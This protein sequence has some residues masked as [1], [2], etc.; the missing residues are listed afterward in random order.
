MAPG[1]SGVAAL[2]IDPAW[3][4]AATPH[5]AKSG[6]GMTGSPPACLTED[7]FGPGEVT[8]V[9]PPTNKDV[10]ITTTT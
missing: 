4:V 8:L 1:P 5:A 6:A 2:L 7:R 9:S 3:T 10:V